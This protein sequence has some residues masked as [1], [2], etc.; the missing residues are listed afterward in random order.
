M[1][2]T[3]NRAFKA[4]PRLL[5]GAEGMYY[6]DVD[7]RPILDG[8][9]G[10]WCVNAGHGRAEITEAIRESA[11]VL[12]FAPGFQMGHP[13]SFALAERLAALLPAPLDRVF[14][15]NS[16]SEAVDT[17][18]KMA[19]A[20]HRANGQPERVLFVGRQRGYHGVGFGGISVGGIAPNRQWTIIWRG[21]HWTQNPGAVNTTFA[22][23]SR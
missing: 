23:G 4:A 6:H 19:L 3:N 15:T 7:G 9:S 16:G 14:F 1:P 21:R 11:G 20:Y 13:S 17:A 12:D 8:I 22:A 5:T 10:L 18:L 2:F